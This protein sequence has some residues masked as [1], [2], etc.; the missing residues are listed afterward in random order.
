MKAYQI[1]CPDAPKKNRSEA[2]LRGLFREGFER[3]PGWFRTWDIPGI[4]HDPEPNATHLTAG[5]FCCTAGHLAIWSKIAA[6]GRGAFVFE[7]D[8][9][10]RVTA[11]L[12]AALTEVSKMPLDLI[13]LQGNGVNERPFRWPIGWK[14]GSPEWSTMAY[15]VSHRSAARLVEDAQGRVWSVADWQLP[16]TARRLRMSIIRCS[17]N[18]FES[19]GGSLLDE[20]RNARNLAVKK[21]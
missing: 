5:E 21:P 8:A 16:E 4:R 2:A 1:F 7:D 3:F 6:S 19:S 17:Q 18:L 15:W 14:S 11:G 13:Y 9:I 20:E 12:H 10:P